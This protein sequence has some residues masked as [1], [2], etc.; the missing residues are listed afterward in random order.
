[1]LHAGVPQQLVLAMAEKMS[2]SN[3]CP[4]VRTWRTNSPD[5][6]IVIFTD[7]MAMRTSF[8]WVMGGGSRAWVQVGVSW[9]MCHYT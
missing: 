6:R 7:N 4:T 1:M 8:M 5:A 3:V 2:A 9:L